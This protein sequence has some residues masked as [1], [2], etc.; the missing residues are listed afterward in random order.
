[1][2]HPDRPLRIALF[3]YSTRPRGS[4]IHTLEL[5]EALHQQ[6]HIVCVYALDKEGQGFGRDLSCSYHLIPALPVQGG[7]DDLIRQR[8]Q[9]VVIFLDNDPLQDGSYDIYHAQD[10]ITANALILLRD[11]SKIP[12]VVR[13]VHHVEAYNSPYLRECQDRSIDRPDLCLCVSQH[14]QQAVQQQYQIRPDRVINGVKGDRFSPVSTVRQAQ[15][16]QTFGL[17]GS[18]IYLTVGGIEPRKN[19]ILLLKAFAQVLSD[20][21]QAQLVIAGGATL[22]DYQS[23]RDEF[24][25]RVQA[26]EIEIGRSLVLPG[27]VS[28]ADLPALYRSANA[29][30]FPSTKEGWG[31]VVLE[32]IAAGLPV[33]TANRPPFTEFLTTG[34]AVLVDPEDVGAIAQG[35]LELSQPAVAQRLV[36]ASQPI[37]QHYTWERSAHLHVAAYRKLLRAKP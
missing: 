14:W 18:P 6:G 25:A 19:S 3:T 21:P 1:M 2:I 22:F 34:Q 28:D 13:T 23:Y 4:V 10:C 12:S 17:Y 15:I 31:L 24:F 29:F 36:Q 11:Q 32:A 30:V 33:L 9:E 20:Q 7:V 5:A 26:L 8:I 16:Q 27:V 35:M 37:L